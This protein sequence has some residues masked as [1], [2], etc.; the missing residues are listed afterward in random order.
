MVFIWDYVYISRAHLF[1]KN[2]V[3]A[4]IADV[5]KKKQMNGDENDKE[6]MILYV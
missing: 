5:Q 2:R 6:E 4:E 1:M 3:N